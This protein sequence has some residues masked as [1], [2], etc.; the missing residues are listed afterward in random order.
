MSER[1]YRVESVTRNGDRLVE[2]L[3]DAEARERE[4]T[5]FDDAS[6]IALVTVNPVD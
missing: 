1:T 2:Q 4:Q 5:P 3:P 6:N